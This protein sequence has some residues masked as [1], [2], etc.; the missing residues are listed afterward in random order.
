MML[1]RYIG[2]KA[3]YRR[4]AVIALPIFAQN[5]ITNLVSLLD[6]VMVGKVGTLAFTGV[7]IVNQ[8]MLV[9]NLCIFGANSGAGI[10]T[11][12]FHGSGDTKNIRYSH[13]VKL[14][15]CMGLAIMGIA[16]FAFAG[17]PLIRLF[18]QGE[19]SA[20]DAASILDH[21]MVYLRVMLWGLIPF[22]LTNAYAGTL[23]ETGQTIVPM[24]G[25]ICAVLVNLALNYVLI[26]GHFG[27]PAMGEEGAAIATVISR[28]VEL[29]IVAGWAHCNS[30]KNPFIQGLFRSARVPLALLC[31]IIRKGMPL[32]LN[33]FLWASA[34]TFL[35]QCYSTCS[36]DVVPAQNIAVIIQNL[37]SVAAMACGI[38]TGIIMGQLMGSGCHEE[39]VR[40]SNRKLIAL[41]VAVG[42]V[43]G[44][45]L[46]SIS[47][48]FPLLYNTS[49][50]VRHL[51]SQMIRVTAFLFPASAFAITTYYTLRSG[52]QAMI[53][54]LFDSCFMWVFPA[55]LAFVLSRFTDM[56]ILPLYTICQSLE[57]VRCMLGGYMIK[58]GK[59]INN[60]TA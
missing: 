29:V 19:G 50:S 38:S 10:F 37:T 15:F 42:V 7:S 22:A 6:N 16:L 2:D 23:R 32:L 48:V 60:L 53:T 9:F 44:I 24:I 40:D 12:Q 47:E 52:G 11:A 25:G 57:I 4:A 39:E 45:I 56:P 43:G 35:N 31:R 55:T 3:F 46:L 59:W 51:A 58:K 20:E 14:Y 41:N 1:K 21:G 30:K 18:L 13:R 5:C 27:F 36:L 33:E 54:F 26:F 17:T 28:Y 49:D 34:V 8:L